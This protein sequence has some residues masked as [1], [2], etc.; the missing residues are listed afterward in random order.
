VPL[1]VKIETNSYADK[2]SWEV[3]ISCRW[4][5]KALADM[6][7]DNMVPLAGVG[8]IYKSRSYSKVLMGQLGVGFPPGRQ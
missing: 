2:L 1:T 6:I 8:P 5:P 7:D 4:Y 3:R